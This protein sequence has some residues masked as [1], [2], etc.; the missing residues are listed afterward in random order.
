MSDFEVTG[1][2]SLLRKLENMGKEGALIQDKS[3]IEAVQPILE[4]EKDATL[5]KDR[6]GKL[7]KSL[8]ISKVKKSKNGKVVWVGDVDKIAQHG[9]YVEYGSTKSKPRKSRPFMKQAY[10]KNKDEVYKNLKEAI[11]NNIK[12]I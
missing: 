9:W 4:D 6:S 5:F 3:L 12:N 8:K 10:N 2:D 7:R 11:E 1:L